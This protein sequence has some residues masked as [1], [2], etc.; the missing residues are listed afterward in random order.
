MSFAAGSVVTLKSGGVS[1]T[2]VSASGDEIQCIWIGEEGEFFRQTIPSVALAAAETEGDEEEHDEDD[3]DGDDEED[4][5][6]EENKE[7]DEEAT[8]KKR[9]RG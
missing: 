7:G 8:P 4:D 5:E 1:M 6:E 2:V 3:H 9:Q